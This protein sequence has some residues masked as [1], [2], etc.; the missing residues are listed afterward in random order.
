MMENNLEKQQF[1]VMIVGAVPGAGVIEKAELY[2]E[3]AEI[4]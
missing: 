4:A 3:G 1:A 2:A